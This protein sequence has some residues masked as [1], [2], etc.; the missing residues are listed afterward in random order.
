GVMMA[1]GACTCGSLVT[2]APPCSSAAP[3]YCNNEFYIRTFGYARLR[4]GT[5]NLGMGGF[6]LGQS[7][8]GAP[9]PP[10]VYLSMATGFFFLPCRAGSVCQQPISGLNVYL[11]GYNDGRPDINVVGLTPTG[12]DFMAKLMARGMLIDVQHMSDKAVNEVLGLRDEGLGHIPG[13]P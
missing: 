10:S 13:D 8:P 2:S 6:Q 1:A 12:R 4:D 5:A 7:A 9:M 11:P 3:M